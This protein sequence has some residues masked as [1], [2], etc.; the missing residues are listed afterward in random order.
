[1]LTTL[2]YSLARPWSGGG[3]R[4]GGVRVLRGGDAF[5]HG[6]T[7][8]SCGHARLNVHHPKSN[9]FALHLGTYTL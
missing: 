8:K 1:M 6:C 3:F 7:A 2:A 9:K 5:G 4:A